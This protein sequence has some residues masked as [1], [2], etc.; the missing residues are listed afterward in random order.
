MIKVGI[1]CEQL[2]EGNQWGIRK[3]LDSFLKEI[4][5][6]QELAREFKFFLYFCI[7]SFWSNFWYIRSSS[8]I[9]TKY[10][11]LDLLYADAYVYSWNCLFIP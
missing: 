7:R 2:E 11:N 5:H 1:E 8:F 10:D 4:D 3:I 6:R 9:K